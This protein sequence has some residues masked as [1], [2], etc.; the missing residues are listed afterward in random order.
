MFGLGDQIGGHVGGIRGGIRD[1]GDLGGPGLGVDAHNS[2][3]QPFRSHHVDVPG[4]G[5][6]GDGCAETGHPM[7]EHRD[8]LGPADRMD[9]LD[10]EH[11]AQCE[12][13]RVR[14]AAEPGLRRGC[15]GDLPDP[16]HLSG[17]DVHY[18]AG[19]QWGEPARNVETDTFDGDVAQPYP[20][21]LGQDRG[22]GVGIVFQGFGNQAS[23]PDGL[24][25]GLPEFRVELFG[26]L[27]QHPSRDSEGPGNHAV[28]A[29]RVL[30]ERLGAPVTDRVAH[31][32]DSSHGARDV[33]LCPRNM[34]AIVALDACQV[35]RSKHGRSVYRR[36][37]PG[38]RRRRRNGG[39]RFGPEGGEQ[40]HRC[41]RAERP[42]QK[43]RN[44]T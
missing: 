28:K 15:D 21:A 44:R 8:R 32:P 2:P 34:G 3:Q 7:G 13:V 22:G 20:G 38:F 25:E 42:H 17:D 37:P 4:A 41:D 40:H 19:G 10:P 12:D 31:L 1:D 30:D 23:A 43:G 16:S 39:W 18:H 14:P 33:Q 9:L 5:D 36:D 6:H 27:S 26:G 35:N 11:V 29:L 24:L